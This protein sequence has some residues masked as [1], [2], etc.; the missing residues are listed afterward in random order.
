MLYP[1]AVYKQLARVGYGC[2]SGNM[3][4]QPASLI[5]LNALL[6]SSSGMLTQVQPYRKAT[7]GFEMYLTLGNTLLVFAG[8]SSAFVPVKFAVAG[9][10]V[11]VYGLWM[12]EMTPM[13]TFVFFSMLAVF[14]AFSEKEVREH[15]AKKLKKGAGS[16]PEVDIVTPKKSCIRG[17][18][19]APT[20]GSGSGKSKKHK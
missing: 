8:L 18:Q 14:S 3:P 12:A 10:L 16:T 5:D 6:D 4:C 7:A 15:E 11:L 9:L 2:I 19:K 1:G 13:H 17:T 20:P